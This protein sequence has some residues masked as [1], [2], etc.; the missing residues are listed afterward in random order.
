LLPFNKRPRGGDGAGSD[1]PSQRTTTSKGPSS[2]RSV[3]PVSSGRPGAVRSQPPESAKF[4]PE[5]E[6]MF[7]RSLSDDEISMLLPQEMSDTTLPK[8]QPVLPHA[9]VAESSRR[10]SSRVHSAREVAGSPVQTEPAHGFDED[11]FAT[12]VF[13]ASKGNA[14]SYGAAKRPSV[15]STLLARP[16]VLDDSDAGADDSA[17]RQAF[18]DDNDSTRM[19]ASKR[20]P[21]RN[22][23]PSRRPREVD[24]V[25]FAATAPISGDEVDVALR[26]GAGGRPGSLGGLAS[27]RPRSTP[28]P[29]AFARS[30]GM[31][32]ALEPSVPHP[33]AAGQMPLSARVPAAGASA[34]GM[35]MSVSSGAAGEAR[36][37]LVATASG[38]KK[39]SRSGRKAVVWAAALLLVGSAAAAGVFFTQRNA[40]AMRIVSSLL[41]PGLAKR[42][43]TTEAPSSAAAALAPV[44]APAS[45]AAVPPPMVQSPSVV[46]SAAQQP[47]LAASV[48]EAPVGAAS[49]AASSIAAN[50]PQAHAVAAPKPPIGH[51]GVAGVSGVSGVAPPRI[52]VAHVQPPA[53]PKEPKVVKKAVGA[54]SDEDRKAADD[55][56]KLADK[57]LEQS[58]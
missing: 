15:K 48:P 41:D 6:R 36:S 38:G 33:F 53:A 24:D 17:A 3:A 43:A 42:H 8:S 40:E 57:Q 45:T 4:L 52:A 46:D 19:M 22:Q 25:A 1:R 14:P 9:R 26:M 32:G 30:A 7:E 28:P 35:A 58:L 2:A 18:S 23:P 21:G 47:A 11:E 44:A 34:A 31:H 29:P 16:P 27:A 49:A 50:T 55:A 54:L 20:V 12:Q 51:P 39:K 56:K 10:S 37:E 5:R 13:D